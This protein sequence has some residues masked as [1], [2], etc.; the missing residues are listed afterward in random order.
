[1]NHTTADI[2][3]FLGGEVLGAP[4]VALKGFASADSARPGDLTFAENEQ[5]FALAEQSAASAILVSGNLASERKTLIRV[6]NARV[7]CARVLP[8]FFPEPAAPP[9]VHATAQVSASAEIHP[10]AA[11]GPYCVI[12]ERVRIGARV[13]LH[14]G[15]YVGAD[16]ILG[17]ETCLFPNAVLY[18]R[19]QIGA[20]VRIHAGAVIGS[21]GFGYV[22]YEGRHLKVTQVG[23]VIVQDD[24]EIG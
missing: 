23:N 10:S 6:A 1:M 18:P 5:Y 21:D 8:L 11:I 17:E 22:S 14:G 3:R 4:A 19:C 7:A 16:S 2:A 13:V 15:N 9:G 20:R 24:V 12:D